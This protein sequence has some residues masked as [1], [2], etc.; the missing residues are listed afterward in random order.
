MRRGI[1]PDLIGF[2]I[3]STSTNHGPHMDSPALIPVESPDH[4]EIV[5]SL[6]V[7]YQ[8]A[9]G[10]D[11]CFQNFNDELANLPGEYTPPE[12]RLYMCHVGEIP[13][14]C[15]ALRKID[16]RTCEMKRMYVRPQFRG[17]HLGRLLAEKIIAEARTIG[18]EAMRLDTLPA[19]TEAIALYRS[20]GFRP[21]E[22]Y[23]LNPHPGAIYM[24]L[25]LGLP[26]Y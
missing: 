4:I 21:T 14:G 1:I 8:R 2:F 18:Y 3:R 26:P 5:R 22:A 6:F 24:E 20:L 9:I 25:L 23:R 11:L 13:G 17:R 19:M 12:G 7:E 15:V 16:E 10:I